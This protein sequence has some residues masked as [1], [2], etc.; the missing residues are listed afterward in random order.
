MLDVLKRDFEHDCGN[1]QALCCV[2]LTRSASNGY[3]KDYQSWE[4]CPKLVLDNTCNGFSCSVYKS[5]DSLDHSDTCKGYTCA[6]A[7]QQVSQIAEDMNISWENESVGS[8]DKYHFGRFF[9]WVQARYSELKKKTERG[10]L[11]NI[12][13][14]QKA[15]SEIEENYRESRVFYPGDASRILSKHTYK[16]KEVEFALS[17]LFD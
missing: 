3:D 15:F 7:G 10:D 1:C 13:D 12:V 16:P 8:E 6:G 2:V 17:F 14:F 9:V 11:I 5:L 4:A